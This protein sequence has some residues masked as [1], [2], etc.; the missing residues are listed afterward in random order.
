MVVDAAQ[1][2]QS[3]PSTSHKNNTS[4]RVSTPDIPEDDAIK[5][6]SGRDE[7]LY[8]EKN[9]AV[10]ESVKTK[11]GESAPLKKDQLKKQIFTSTPSLKKSQSS[12]SRIPKLSTSRTHSL[13]KV[14]GTSS[15]EIQT[16][17]Q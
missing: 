17:A 16:E 12:L 6:Q 1:R 15:S 10:L 4:S 5:T 11:R 13:D 14:H 2:V 3:K 9:M 8:E 7:E